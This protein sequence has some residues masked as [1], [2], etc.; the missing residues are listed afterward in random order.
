M[1]SSQ[2]PKIQ[3]SS[4]HPWELE[5][6]Y[7]QAQIF[8]KKQNWSSSSVFLYYIH[9][10][11]PNF[12]K[13]LF[14][15]GVTQMSLSYWAGAQYCFEKLR[16]VYP[17]DPDIICNLGIIYWKQKK[18]K[19]ALIFFKFN[20]KNH[21]HHSETAINLAS[22]YVEYNHHAKAI[23]QY[24]D[25]LYHHPK[26]T[27]I[28]FNLAACLQKL[29]FHDNAIFHYRVILQDHASHYDSLYN[30]ACVYWKQKDINASKFYLEQAQKIHYSEHIEFMLKTML[31]KQD[32]FENH[33]AYVKNLF[34][35]YAV[36]YDKHLIQNLDY[37]IPAY[38]KNYLQGKI[39]NQNVVEIG[40]GTGLCGEAIKSVSHHVI[41]IDLSAK[42]LVNARKKACYD[43]L[44]EK[45]FFQFLK[46]Y[47]H[48]IGCVFALDVSPYVLNFVDLL[49]HDHIQEIIFTIEL[50]EE[51]PTVFQPTGRLSFHPNYIEENL[52][53]NHYKLIH[54]KKLSARLQHQLLCDLMFYHIK[55]ERSN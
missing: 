37:Q 18:L 55:K 30:L 34:Q 53:K 28:R 46:D 2:Y 44:H 50:S 17:W 13:A 49:M 16:E 47:E 21:S 19:K 41:G 45:D 26:R 20:R 38:L 7:Q 5:A 29:G 6:L 27:E 39:F 4:P 25:I 42:M 40:C 1:A 35:L 9:Q 51:Y 43:E 14:Q 10:H 24:N 36:D 12:T 8:Y 52:Q 48:P 23:H 15:L 31:D 11:A 54:K 3:I 22:L 33:Q 32:N